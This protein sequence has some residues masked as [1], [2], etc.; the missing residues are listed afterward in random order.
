MRLHKLSENQHFVH[1]IFGLFSQTQFNMFSRITSAQ[2][3]VSWQLDGKKLRFNSFF[4]FILLVFF[5]HSLSH[6]D[7]FYQLVGSCLCCF[8][9]WTLWRQVSE[10]FAQYFTR[11]LSARLLKKSLN[12]NFN[13]P[14]NSSPESLFFCSAQH[15]MCIHFACFQCYMFSD[16]MGNSCM[17]LLLLHAT[18]LNATITVFHATVEFTF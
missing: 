4:N 10:V 6:T 18:K 11:Y 16:Q 2:Y 14:I 9:H 7:E 1:F 5:L 12:I 17:R 15:L 8:Y 13:Y 3:Q